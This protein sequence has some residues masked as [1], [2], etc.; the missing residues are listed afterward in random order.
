[1]LE[2]KEEN[3]KVNV[4]KKIYIKNKSDLE[5][6]LFLKIKNQPFLL[7]LYC[8]IMIKMPPGDE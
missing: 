3:E 6:T 7:F 8:L 2:E 4:K 5:L 1:M